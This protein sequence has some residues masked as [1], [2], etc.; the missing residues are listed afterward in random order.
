MLGNQAGSGTISEI[1]I[2]EQYIPAGTNRTLLNT[3]S[4]WNING[5]YTGATISGTYQGQS[6]YNDDYWFTAVDD[7]V[8]IRLIRG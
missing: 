3:S 1:P 8:W 6:H 2:V 4:N 7:N 5:T